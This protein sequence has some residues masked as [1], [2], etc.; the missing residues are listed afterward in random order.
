M[1]VQY[2]YDGHPRLLNF[3]V[4]ADG[5]GFLCKLKSSKDREK[6]KDITDI[7][8]FNNIIQIQLKKY[9]EERILTPIIFDNIYKGDGYRFKI[10][11]N[12]LIKK[13]E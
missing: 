8:S 5:A 1:K 6:A 12:L 13:L 9:I 10:R 4:K 3:S 2:D 11:M 7:S